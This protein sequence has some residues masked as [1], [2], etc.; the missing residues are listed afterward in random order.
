M[1]SGKNWKFSCTQFVIIY[2]FSS[3]QK[4]LVIHRFVG[5]LSTWSFPRLV[6]LFQNLRSG[7]PTLRCH[8]VHWK[9]FQEMMWWRYLLQLWLSLLLVKF[10]LEARLLCHCL[11]YLLW[12][13]VVC[14][15]L[16]RPGWVLCSMHKN[17]YYKTDSFVPF[18]QLYFAMKS[19]LPT[20]PSRHSRV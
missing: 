18:Q 11:L 17:N 7:E 1:E 6:L 20:S 13:H 12:F 5:Q 14:T 4:T 19:A 8:L 9:P 15:S 10:A 2:H 16:L 3:C